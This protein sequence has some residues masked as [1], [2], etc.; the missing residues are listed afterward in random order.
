MQTA[1][2]LLVEDDPSIIKNLTEFLS[3]EGFFVKSVFGQKDALEVLDEKKTDLVLL[4]ITLAQGN[5]FAACARIKER[6]QQAVPTQ[7]ACFTHEK[8]SSEK[9]QGRAGS[10]DPGYYG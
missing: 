5:G 4:D 9:R 8:C 6:Y 7:R 1:S 2:V 10:S 3:G